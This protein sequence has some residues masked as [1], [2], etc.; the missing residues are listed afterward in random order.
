[1]NKKLLDL[2]LVLIHFFD[3]H[4][5]IKHKII[6]VLFKNG[7]ID[8]NID[9]CKLTYARMGINKYKQLFLYKSDALFYT[10]HVSSLLRLFLNTEV[11]E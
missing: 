4:R 10:S 2:F 3:T 7:F 9:A 6:V 5:R 8:Y 11:G 1:M